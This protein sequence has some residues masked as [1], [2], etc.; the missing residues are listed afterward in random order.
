MKEDKEK[1]ENSELFPLKGYIIL[2]IIFY[3]FCALQLF[4]VKKAGG[5]TEGLFFFFGVIAIGF[6]IVSIFDY[7]YDRWNKK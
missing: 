4:I 5:E 7:L 1:K 3:L 6:T 2:N